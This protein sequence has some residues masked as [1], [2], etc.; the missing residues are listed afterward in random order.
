MAIPN[1]IAVL[2]LSGVVVKLT[3]AQFYPDERLPDRPARAKTPPRYGKT[4][5]R[6]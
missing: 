1:L 2:A 4:V 5:S 6:N 3:Q